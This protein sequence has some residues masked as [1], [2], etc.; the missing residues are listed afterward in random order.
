MTQDALEALARAYDREDASQRG[1]P[2]PWADESDA[3]FPAWRAE[4]LA[5]AEVAIKAYLGVR[6]GADMVSMLDL[7]QILHDPEN[8]PSQFGTIPAPKRHASPFIPCDGCDGHDCIGR[9]VYP[10]PRVR[11]G[12]ATEGEVTS[13]FA[14][15]RDAVWR[16]LETVRQSA[17]SATPPVAQPGAVGISDAMVEAVWGEL[18]KR[19]SKVPG[20]NAVRYALEAALSAPTVEGAGL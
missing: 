4:R 20:R 7:E 3:T 15:A 13:D 6:D 17:L 1:E 10:E 9:C 8:Q 16:S 18:A 5:C 14:V 11:D 19:C 2:S 12:E